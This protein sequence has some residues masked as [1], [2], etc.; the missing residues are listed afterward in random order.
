MQNIEN[1]WQIWSHIQWLSQLEEVASVISELISRCKD[2]YQNYIASRLS[3]RKTNARMYWFLL[4]TFCS[5][6]KV[7]I[8]S[9]LL[10]NNKLIS[11]FE[12]KADYFIDFFESQCMP[13][14]NNSKIPETQ[15]YVT[16]TSGLTLIFEH[17]P[18]RLSEISHFEIFSHQQEN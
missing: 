17:L 14:N 12:V 15:S 16:N 13:L 6:K 5:G 10:I 11:D 8:I 1:L 4:I 7:P 9:P 3:D 18:S 2:E